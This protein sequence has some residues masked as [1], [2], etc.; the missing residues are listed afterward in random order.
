MYLNRK[1]YS[2]VLCVLNPEHTLCKIDRELRAIIP[3]FS[4]ID[5]AQLLLFVEYMGGFVGSARKCC[6]LRL[7]KAKIDVRSF[8]SLKTVCTILC[9][10]E[11][12]RRIYGGEVYVRL[13]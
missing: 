7:V 10:L 5:M 2:L 11:C 1:M 8:F 6:F 3:F 9:P 12:P 13:A 4:N